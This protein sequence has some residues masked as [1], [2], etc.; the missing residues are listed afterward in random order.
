MARLKRMKSG[1]VLT[2]EI[3]EA[4]ADE[5]EAGYD[6]EVAT[7]RKVG[8]PSLGRGVSP[9]LDLRI[10]PDLAQALHERAE[11]E[12]RSVSAVAREALRQYL[13]S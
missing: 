13:A 5:A 6:L 3:E 1:T 11:E 9:R 2:P 4:L 8:R 12:H 10:E 7:P